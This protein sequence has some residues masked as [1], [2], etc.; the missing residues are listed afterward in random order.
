MV[1]HAAPATP[2]LKLMINTRSRITFNSC[3]KYKKYQRNLT[4]S[5]CTQVRGKQVVK[6]SGDDSGA[7]DHNVGICI[8]K[9]VVR[10]VH[11]LQQEGACPANLK[12]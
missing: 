7:D 2:I 5:N 10:C 8:L 12:N 1:A 11:Q 9:N 4:V 3:G 6:N